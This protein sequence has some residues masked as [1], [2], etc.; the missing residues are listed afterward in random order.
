[1]NK[2]FRDLRKKLS[3]EAKKKVANKTAAMLVEMPLC[4]LRQ[5]RHLSQ[6][7]LA[8]VLDKK[9]GS[10]SRIEK[11]TDMYLSTLRS[12]IEAMGGQLDIIARFPEG[13]VHVNQFEQIDENDDYTSAN[14]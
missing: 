1:V 3:P 13:D 10:V 5:A 12:Y 7:Q 14:Q 6:E 9:Q 4:E 11:Q 8:V 2:K